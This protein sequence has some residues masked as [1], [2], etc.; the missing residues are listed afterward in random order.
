MQHHVVA[1]LTVLETGNALSTPSIVDSLIYEEIIQFGSVKRNPEKV[2]SHGIF[3]FRCIIL[4]GN[5]LA[6]T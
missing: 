5:R 6:L 4:L 2:S 1:V 3:W